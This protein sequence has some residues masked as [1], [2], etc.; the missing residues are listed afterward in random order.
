MQR[1]LAEIR[2]R[3]AKAKAEAEEHM[4]LGNRTR[5]AIEVILNSD[6]ITP[7]LR[8]VTSLGEC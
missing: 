8:A 7:I 5:A 2:V 3:L 4:R 1:R 6:S